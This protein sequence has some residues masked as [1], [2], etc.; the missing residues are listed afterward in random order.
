MTCHIRGGQSGAGRET[1]IQT[2]PPP[3]GPNLCQIR[4]LP[5]GAAADTQVRG[6]HTSRCYHPSPMEPPAGPWQMSLGESGGPWAGA[7]WSSHKVCRGWS[8]R[9]WDVV[10]GPSPLLGRSSGCDWGLGASPWGFTVAC[11]PP[12]GLGVL[13]RFLRGNR[14]GAAVDPGVR[15]RC[16]A[17]AGTLVSRLLDSGR[18]VC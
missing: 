1:G 5:S 18:W 17:P 16:L 11:A 3:P 6:S 15:G 9:Y 14:S 8:L 12:Q 7:P 10:Q 4:C 2:A 13:Y